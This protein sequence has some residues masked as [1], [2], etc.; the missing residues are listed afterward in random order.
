MCKIMQ[1]IFSH[2]LEYGAVQRP[3]SHWCTRMC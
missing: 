2:S 1:F 3:L